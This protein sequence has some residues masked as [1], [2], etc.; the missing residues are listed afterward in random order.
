MLELLVVAAVLAILGALLLPALSR[1]KIPA[2]RV[3]CV[4]NLRQLGVAALLYW[5]EN[6]GNCFRYAGTYT[7]GG[8]LY[9]FGWIEA[10]AEGQRS[11]DAACGRKS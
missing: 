4:S 7:N 5:D 10:G 6:G 3:R 2:L 8:Q 11:F 1:G 9:W